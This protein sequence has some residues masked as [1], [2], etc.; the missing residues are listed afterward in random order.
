MKKK[1]IV[2]SLLGIGIVLLVVSVVLAAM[3]AAG[4]NIIGG[5]DL[6]TFLFV[7][8]SEKGGL[9]SILASIGLAAI[10]AAV[11]AVVAKKENPK[12]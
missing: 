7:L 8:V 4:K 10:I 12:C 9:Y 1:H 6:P 3:A 11:V 2:L 5:A